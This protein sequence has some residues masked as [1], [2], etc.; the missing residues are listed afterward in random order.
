MRRPVSEI[1][2]GPGPINI[3]LSDILALTAELTF[4]SE[5]LSN[6]RHR[7]ATAAIVYPYEDPA[8]TQRCALA[9]A[10]GH[11]P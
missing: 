7:T 4:Q 1:Q 10:P 8:A 5:I 3:V 2:N 6:F 9:T 11:Y